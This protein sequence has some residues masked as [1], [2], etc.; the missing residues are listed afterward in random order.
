[1][2]LR[3]TPRAKNLTAWGIDVGTTNSTLC[4]AR[5]AAGSQ[6]AEEPEVQWLAQPTLAGPFIGSLVPSMVALHQGR[7]YVGEGAKNLR[8]LTAG[9]SGSVVRNVSLF[10]DCKNEIG[11]S[12]SY[13]NAPEG[14]RSPTAIAGKVLSFLRREGISGAGQRPGRPRRGRWASAR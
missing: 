1:M 5:L 8:A 11:A 4:C 6:T 3:L 14:Y 2:A 10:H 7:E 13:P 9:A 12:R